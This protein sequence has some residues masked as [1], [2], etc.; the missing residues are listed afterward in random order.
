MNVGAETEFASITAVGRPSSAP[1]RGRGFRA[2]DA[3]HG[4]VRSADGVDL[5]R[6]EAD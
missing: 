5:E 3:E 1:G 2:G 4:T 6:S